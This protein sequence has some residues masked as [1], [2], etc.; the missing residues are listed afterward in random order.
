MIPRRV[1]RSPE[2]DRDIEAL[3]DYIAENSGP[4]RSLRVIAGLRSFIESLALASRRGTDRS[5]LLPGMRTLGY[6]GWLTIAFVVSD[7]AVTVL[8]VF[9]RG[10]DWESEFDG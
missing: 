5:D 9:P 1:V 10:R 8:R 7:E 6:R 3:L 4:Q 2:A